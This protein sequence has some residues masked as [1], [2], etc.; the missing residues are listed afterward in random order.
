M[1]KPTIIT[2]KPKNHTKIH[3]KHHHNTLYLEIYHQGTGSK[4][5][6]SILM[7]PKKKP[8]SKAPSYPNTWKLNLILMTL[9][10]YKQ[11]N[12]AKKP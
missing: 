5:S 10:K 7:N 2:L 12:I 8:P 9:L 4:A 11:A 6:L 3:N 1:F